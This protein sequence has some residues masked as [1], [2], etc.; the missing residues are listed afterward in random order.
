MSTAEQV[1]IEKIWRENYKLLCYISRQRS[2]PES[3]CEDLAQNCISN[4]SNQKAVLSVM[5]DEEVKMY[6]LAAIDNECNTW[7]LKQM[8]QQQ[9]AEKV[10]S[11][12]PSVENSP[13]ADIIAKLDSKQQVT[14]I[15]EKLS[16]QERAL[17][18]GK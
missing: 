7:F 13:E 4:L 15:M 5:T 11:R 6:L 16:E 1:R 17:V 14:E 2:I 12:S 10:A 8:R 18:I 9:I 3:E